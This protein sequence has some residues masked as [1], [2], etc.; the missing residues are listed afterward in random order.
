[1]EGGHLKGNEIERRRRSTFFI[2]IK[3]CDNSA[4]DPHVGTAQALYPIANGEA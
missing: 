3:Q 1:M 4:S 2:A